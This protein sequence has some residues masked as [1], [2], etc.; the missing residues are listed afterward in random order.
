MTGASALLKVDSCAVASDAQSQSPRPLPLIY[1]HL[2]FLGPRSG[3]CTASELT[4]SQY[5][6]DVMSLAGTTLLKN[7]MCL[8]Q[9]KKQESASAPPVPD[10]GIKEKGQEEDL[11]IFSLIF[12]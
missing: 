1:G 7:E 3:L 10:P 2:A 6:L 8:L 11:T 12:F 9:A 4:A 5:C